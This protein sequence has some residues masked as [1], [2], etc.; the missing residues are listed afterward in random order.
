MADEYIKLKDCK[1]RTL[2][3][4]R[5]R[6]SSYGVFNK[7]TNGFTGI[8]EKFKIEYLFEEFHWDTG[9][10]FG[11]AKPDKELEKLPDDIL[12]KTMIGTVDE[13]TNRPVKFD[14]MVANGG[15]G[16]VFEDTDKADGRI[17]PV[18]LAND[19]LFD[20][21]KNMEKKYAE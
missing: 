8:R 2:Y 12:I 3:K 16:W 17:S 19:K 11:T 20:W 7:D 5:A 21:L 15:R 14:G 13:A 4:I 10:P 1:D 9:A 18:G 6:N